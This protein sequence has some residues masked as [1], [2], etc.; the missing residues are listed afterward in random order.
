M[1]VPLA[2]GASGSVT[3]SI[4]SL[5]VAVNL[6]P[7][8]ATGIRKARETRR[9]QHLPPGPGSSWKEITATEVP[10]G[11]ARG[12]PE[13]LALF[14]RAWLTLW[15]V[16]VPVETEVPWGYGAP[17]EVR[18]FLQGPQPRAAELVRAVRIMVEFVRGFRALH[19][20]GPCVTVFGSA[21]F[22]E[23]HPY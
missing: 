14:D 2:S 20:V 19:F 17:P 13:F 11:P 8:T 3:V 9:A 21:R 5:N 7:E 1:V 16:R 23:D 18:R 12:A 10:H 6:S 4:P 15:G 22:R